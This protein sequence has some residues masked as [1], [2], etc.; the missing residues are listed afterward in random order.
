MVRGYKMVEN[1]CTIVNADCQAVTDPGLNLFFLGEGEW[2]QKY[3]KYE[4]WLN[5]V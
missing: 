2:G 3:K 1:H 5:T 4:N